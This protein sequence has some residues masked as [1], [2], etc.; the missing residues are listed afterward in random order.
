ML[1]ETTMIK[2]LTREDGLVD[3]S[4]TAA[5][6]TRQVRAFHPWPGTFTYW[7][8]KQLKIIDATAQQ[9][10]NGGRTGEVLGML[11]DGLRIVTGNGVLEITRLQEEGRKVVSAKEFMA[12]HADVVG[13]MFGLPG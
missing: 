12:G 3:W 9:S 2:K 10:A 1:L 4:N 13:A 11:G 8:G 7:R 5:Y 6:I